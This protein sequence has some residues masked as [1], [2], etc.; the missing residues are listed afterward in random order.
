MTDPKLIGAIIGLARATEN[1]EHL[2][3]ADTTA[4][5]LRILCSDASADTPLLLAQ[6]ETEKRKLVPNCFE[7]AEP[8]GRTSD[9]DLSRL[10]Q[11]DAD[12]RE[13]KLALLADL[14]RLAQ[15]GNLDEQQIDLLYKALIIMG[16]EYYPVD[17]L[18]QLR[19]QLMP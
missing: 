18:R 1:N 19:R 9:Y 7:C 3:T 6:V 4:I 13:E 17:Q 12:I 15:R 2:I 14:H 11:E 5:I 16:I 8:C 10:A